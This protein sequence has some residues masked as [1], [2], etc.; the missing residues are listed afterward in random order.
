MKQLLYETV[1]DVYIV[2]G[3]LA[4][5]SFFTAGEA[6]RYHDLQTY[7]HGLRRGRGKTATNMED[8]RRASRGSRTFLGYAEKGTVPAHDTLHARLG[9]SVR[10][11]GFWKT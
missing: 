5:I 11:A 9:C 4:D 7:F 2:A 6:G 10:T 1:A 8:F 3:D